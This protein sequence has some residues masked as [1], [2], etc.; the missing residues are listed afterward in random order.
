MSQVVQNAPTRRILRISQVRA[1]TNLSATSIY[2][3]IRAGRFPEAKQIAGMR[4]NGW[5]SL[6]VEAWINEQLDAEE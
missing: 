2:N 1:L 6:A 3:L 5:D 4:A